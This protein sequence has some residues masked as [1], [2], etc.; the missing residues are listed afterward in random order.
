MNLS[1]PKIYLYFNNNIKLHKK[2]LVRLLKKLKKNKKKVCGLGASTKGN[3]ILQYCKI[4][5]HLIKN[6][7]EINKDKFNK[8]TPGT[9]IQILDDKK[10]TK[11]NCDYLVVL[12]WHFKDHIVKREK[13][14]KE[15]GIQFI[16]P[17]PEIEVI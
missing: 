16:F 8:F 5:K 7:Y 13:N 1:N 9:N 11:K 17:L 12:P 15:Q 6:I 2:S 4:D 3:V 14:L 10:I